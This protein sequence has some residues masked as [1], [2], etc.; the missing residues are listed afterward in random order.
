MSTG[1]GEVGE[2]DTS[3]H[4][5]LSLLAL[6]RRWVL[7]EFDLQIILLSNLAGLPAFLLAMY[8]LWNG[9]FDNATRWLATVGLLIL[10]ASLTAVLR[11]RLVRP[12]RT[13]SS[14]LA[15]L[16]EGDFSLRARVP[17]SLKGPLASAFHNSRPSSVSS[18]WERSKRRSSS[19]G[20]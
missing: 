9:E 5:V 2:A 16:R 12:I 4:G 1:A 8:L 14:V 15:A 11:A 19:D 3:R 10:W 20:Y 18:G 17:R 7:L 6:R 13:L